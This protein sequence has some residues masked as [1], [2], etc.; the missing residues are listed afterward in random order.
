LPNNNPVGIQVASGV[1]L[2]VQLAPKTIRMYY[3]TED[4]LERVASLNLITAVCLAFFGVCFG[5]F[6]SFY[7]TLRTADIRDPSTHA[8]FVSIAVVTA[9]LAAFFLVVFLCG[10]IK[11]LLDL[12][13]AKRTEAIGT[14][15][16][17]SQ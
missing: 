17:A 6:V 7:T 5:G 9:I 10:L 15:M 2:T 13:R 11:S 16:P 8:T 3:L 14:V 12:R 4:Q 1:A